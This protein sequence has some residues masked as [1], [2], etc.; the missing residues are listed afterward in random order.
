MEK[1]II[2]TISFNSLISG[3]EVFLFKQMNGRMNFFI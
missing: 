3:D 2:A 1:F